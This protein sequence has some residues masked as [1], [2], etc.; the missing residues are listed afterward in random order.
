M[1]ISAGMSSGE[2]REALTALD[3]HRVIEFSDVRG[4]VCGFDED[5]KR[6]P[7]SRLDQYVT[8]KLSFTAFYCGTV[9]PA[10]PRP[11]RRPLV[12]A[13]PPR[14][15]TPRRAQEK[16]AEM[17][18]P[19][20]DPWEPGVIKRHCGTEN[21]AQYRDASG[22]TQK[23]VYGRIGDYEDCACEFGL[24]KLKSFTTSRAKYPEECGPR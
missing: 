1:E 20:N 17:G 3:E 4:L 7:Q 2:L 6:N 8:N 13:P 18:K 9:R 14:R 24:A 12:R 5:R 10:R 16:W 15:L 22:K 21:Y 23:V 19:R 11:A